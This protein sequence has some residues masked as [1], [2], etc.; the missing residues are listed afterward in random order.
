[1]KVNELRIGNYVND[2]LHRE[3]I[4]KEI[5]EEHLIFYLSNGSKIKHNIKT[6][7]PIEMNREW[8]MNFGFIEDEK[9]EL[10]LKNDLAS[11]VQT[12]FMGLWLIR[13]DMIGRTE[14]IT[15]LNEDFLYV[16]QLQNLYFALTG[17]E[18]KLI[19]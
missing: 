18:L 16:H 3:V 7:E 10:I 9:E 11:I 17:A 4:I 12:C 13:V 14:T 5:R 15:M 19:P 1:M 6:F 2:R 8:L